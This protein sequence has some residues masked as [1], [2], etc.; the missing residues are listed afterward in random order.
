MED[1]EIHDVAEA[2]TC[3]CLFAPSSGPILKPQL[4]LC[5]ELLLGNW[6]VTKA[7]W[8]TPIITHYYFPMSS[9]SFP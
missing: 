8:I 3:L 1:W 9:P 6:E 7:E 4:V 5:I 2:Q